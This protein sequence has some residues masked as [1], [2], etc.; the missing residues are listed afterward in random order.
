MPVPNVTTATLITSTWG[1]QIADQINDNETDIAALEARFPVAGSNLA[2]DAVTTA[3]LADSSVT[4]AKI[5]DGTIATTDLANGAVSTAKI[6][7]GQITTVKIADGAV[8]SAKIADGTIVN[9]DI[10]ASAAI[11][12]SKI[13]NNSITATQIGTNAVGADELANNAVDTAAIQNG[14]VTNA[15]LT[16][17]TTDTAPSGTTMWRVGRTVFWI[18]TEVDG[19]R[20]GGSGSIDAAFRP[21]ANRRILMFRSEDGATGIGTINSNGAYNIPSPGAFNHWSFY[22]FWRI[23]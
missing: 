21:P 8:T 4:S 15:K 3:K 14:A 11:A 2:N 6:G 18:G 23:P 17:E 19:G 13:A 7:N 20:S 10:N 9:A 22:A 16:D 1:N 12:G 5:A